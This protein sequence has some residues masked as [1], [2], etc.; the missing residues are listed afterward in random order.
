MPIH[1]KQEL[2]NARQL[3]R[4]QTDAEQKLWSAI[5]NR[6]LAGLKFRR[7][8][9]IGAY[10]VDFYCHECR[11][12]LELDGSQHLAQLE[13][14]D[15]RTCFL[16]GIRVLRFWNNEILSNIE[17]VLQQIYTEAFPLPEGEGWGEGCCMHKISV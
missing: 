12:V 13:Y 15:I 5:R 2:S 8:V 6:Q 14:D 7:Q 3:R 11:L 10:I 17:G 1:T 16:Q 9:P 4:Q